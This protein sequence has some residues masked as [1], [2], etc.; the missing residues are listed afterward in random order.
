MRISRFS[1]QKG[2]IVLKAALI[3]MGPDGCILFSGGDQPH[4]G[5]A[6]VGAQGELVS[7]TVF[8]GHKEEII[9]R[10]LAKQMSERA[11]LR[12]FILS[13]GIHVENISKSEIDDVLQMCRE[14]FEQIAGQIPSTD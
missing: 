11:L 10:E 12:H 4:I 14:L 8:H 6:A 7:S 3:Q 1:V 5:A 9:V 2:R 13:C